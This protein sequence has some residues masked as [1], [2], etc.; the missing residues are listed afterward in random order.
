[1]MTDAELEMALP[2]PTP[3]D[4]DPTALGWRYLDGGQ[5]VV[6]L[7]QEDLLYQAEDDF[8]VTNYCHV[9]DTGYLKEVLRLRTA[10]KPG[11]RV[12]SDHCIDFQ[13]EGMGILGPDVILLNG[14]DRPW[15]INRGT[16]PV[17]DMGARPLYAFEIT[18]PSTRVRDFRERLDQYYRVGV[19]VSVVIDASYG[20][21][22]KPQGVVAFQAG[23]ERYERLPTRSDGRV[24]IEVADIWVSVEHDRLC[25]RD[26]NGSV[27]PDGLTALRELQENTRHAEKAIAEATTAREQ[28]RL[29]TARFEAEKA[30]AEAAVALA[31]AEKTRAA[32]L[33]AERDAEK[34]NSLALEQKYKEL[35]AELRRIRGE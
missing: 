22:R 35:E 29:E 13:V 34:A 9:E 23:P 17:K 26:E 16:F 15:D 33:A 30:R 1:M 21:G 7:R 3:T 4:D 19:P 27:I 10:S 18:S 2:V 14:E 24:W 31:E 5:R 32:E 20:G 28:V 11:I 6:P 8:L 25:C 12:F